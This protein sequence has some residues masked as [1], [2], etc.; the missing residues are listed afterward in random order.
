MLLILQAS[1]V[2]G[3]KRSMGPS[4]QAISIVES[5]AYEDLKPRVEKGLAGGTW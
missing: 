5:H 2:R 3:Y 1:T 4:I